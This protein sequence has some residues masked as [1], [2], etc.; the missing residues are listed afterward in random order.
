MAEVVVKARA[1]GNSLGI[2]I[3]NEIVKSE[4]IKANEEITVEF[5]KKLR[6]PRPD[7]FGSMKDWKIDAQKLKDRLRKESDW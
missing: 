6:L 2:T 3:P 5:R 4:N 7:F 1:W